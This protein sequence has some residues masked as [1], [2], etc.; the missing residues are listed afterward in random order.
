M[1]EYG[2]DTLPNKTVCAMFS[3]LNFLDERIYAA[4]L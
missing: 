2:H 3:S 1:A 4:F